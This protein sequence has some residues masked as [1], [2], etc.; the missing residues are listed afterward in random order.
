MFQ[1]MIIIG[2]LEHTFIIRIFYT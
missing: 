2:L 1:L